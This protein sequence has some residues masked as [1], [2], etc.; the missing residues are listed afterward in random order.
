MG[1][2]NKTYVDWLMETNPRQLVNITGTGARDHL[3]S[4]EFLHVSTNEL[5]LDEEQDGGMF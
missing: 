2:N 3:Q 4:E 1:V 5:D